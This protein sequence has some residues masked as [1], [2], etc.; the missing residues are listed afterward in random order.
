VS[1]AVSSLPWGLWARQ[2]AGIMRL[3]VR[4]NFWGMRALPM[5][6]LALAPALI[7]TIR[8][9]FPLK[10]QDV[11]F[12]SV[13]YAGL[14]QTFYLRLAVFFGSVGVFTSL[15]RGDLLE[16]SLHYYLLMPVRREVLT[17]GKYVSGLVATLVLFTAGTAL[18]F[19][20][21]YLPYG[22]QRAGR[23]FFEGPGLEHLSSYLGVTVLACLGYGAVFLLMGLLVNNPMIPAALV[24]AWESIHFLLPPALRKISV[25]HYLLSLC[26]VPAPQGPLALMVEPTPA[27]IAIPALLLLTAVLLAAASLRA[28]RLEITYAAD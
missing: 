11:G 5:Y 19:V 23:F 28:R 1:A 16:K 3:E 17:I 7:M 25:I 10:S 6:S 22:S 4:K 13:V 24:L 8:L 14:F 26:P 18:S 20:L 21:M 27:W 12:A 2:I 9:A 15:F